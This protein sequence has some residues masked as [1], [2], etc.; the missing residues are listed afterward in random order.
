MVDGTVH[1]VARCCWCGTHL[2]KWLGH[3]WCQ[4]QACQNRQREHAIVLKK[5]TGRKVEE[6]Y[7]FAPLPSQAEFE[8][9]KAPR[10]L[11]GG[12]AG[13]GKSFGA[14]RLAYRKALRIKGLNVLLVRKTYPELERTHIKA[15]RREAAEIGFE[16]VE[17]RREARFPNGSVIECGHLEDADAVQKYLSAEY[18]LIIVDEAVQIEPDALMELM[19][20]ARTSNPEVIAE[21]GAE[22]WLPT[23]PG[24]PSHALLKDMHITKTPDTERYPA[25][26][27]SYKPEQ[28]AYIRATLDDNPY[29]DPDYESLSLSGLRKARHE[30]LRHGDWDVA[31]GQFFDMFSARTHVRSV[32]V[33][34]PIADAIEA[35]DWGFTS[36]GTVAWYVPLADNHWH[37]LA[38]WKFQRMT[39]EEVAR[40]IQQRRA[41]LGVTNVRYAVWD[42]SIFNKTGHGHGESIAETMGRFGVMCRKGDNDRVLGWMRLAAHYRPGPDGVP[43]LTYDPSCTYSVRSIPALL[44]DK[45]NPEDVDTDLDD[46]A[47]DRDRYFAQSRPLQWTH[48]SLGATVT[49]PNSWGFWKRVHKRGTERRS[50][51]A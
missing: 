25:L 2:V 46:H 27:R 4:Q 51:I 36:P 45:T 26:A 1:P 3:W 19:S 34:R 42:P 35:G 30:Q 44:A 32:H 5:T 17:S 10:K 15:M 13:P 22:V 6:T 18:D 21:G 38:E 50:A 39:A 12:S 49:P 41:E 33:A 7:W 9:V 14:R 37:V 11:W 47:A 29:L 23:N 48:P 31:E 24:G 28:W 16:W 20:R 43:W 40:G 8:R